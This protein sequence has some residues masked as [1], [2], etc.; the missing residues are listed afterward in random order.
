MA[1][2]QPLP[3]F[4]FGKSRHQW[5]VQMLHCTVLPLTRPTL[6]P[7]LLQ[8]SLKTLHISQFLLVLLCPCDKMATGHPD[9]NLA[10][11]S[12]LVMSNKKDLYF[13]KLAKKTLAECV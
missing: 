5:Q 10:I 6:T 4:R 1:T 3:L 11:F 7:R 8:A 2:G 13:R 9:N 12:F